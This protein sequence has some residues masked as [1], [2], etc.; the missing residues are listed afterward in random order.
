MTTPQ[1]AIKRLFSVVN[2]GTPTS[3]PEN[4]DG[5]VQWATPVDLGVCDGGKLG[6]TMRTLTDR[7]LRSGSAAV[8]PGSLI[9]SS[10]APIGYVVESTDVVAFNQGCKGLVPT[11]D[12]DVRYFRYAL[13]SMTKALAARGQGSTF[14]ELSS[15]ALGALRVPAPR[16][17]AQR[18]I[19]DDLDTETAR[20]DALIAK[21]RL[22]VQRLDERISAMV[23][24]HVGRSMIA[25]GSETAR[26]IR[27]LLRKVTVPASGGEIVTA[28]RDGQVT[29]RSLRRAEGYTESGGE[30]VGYQRVRTS[31]VV[32][33]GLDGFAGAIGTSEADG[34]CSPVYHVM[35]PTDGGDSDFYGRLLRELA[36]TNYIGLFATS[37]RERAVDLRNWDLF[38]RIPIPQVPVE[39]QREIGRRIR[40]LRPLKIAVSRSEAL[41]AEHRQALITAAVTGELE[42]PPRG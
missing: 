3:A 22:M 24:E 21:K 28:Y 12:L 20:I 5:D 23:G 14:M 27:R 25:D 19:A 34:I 4:W 9:V 29:A 40:A 37:T 15:A 7:G 42:I 16:V 41:A 32:A 26:E 35:E 11:R 13:G 31:D 10:R 18:A 30:N 6:P 33:H 2:G 38:G 1:V 8:P 39:D 17:D 36:V